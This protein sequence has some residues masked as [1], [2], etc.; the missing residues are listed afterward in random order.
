MA[1]KHHV[2]HSPGKILVAAAFFCTS[3]ILSWTNQIPVTAQMALHTR[4]SKL[5]PLGDSALKKLVYDSIFVVN[6][7]NP[8]MTE[9]QGSWITP[10]LVPRV[11]GTPAN[12]KVRKFIS[13]KMEKLGWNL[14]LDKFKSATPIGQ[15]EFVNI[16]ATKDPL[17]RNRVIVAAHY[18]SKYFPEPNNFVGAT[19]SAGP[20]AILLDLADSL[21]PLLE[22][23]KRVL[24]QAKDRG[25]EL[26]LEEQEMMDT[27]LQVVFF[28]GEEAFKEWSATDSIYGARHLASKWESTMITTQDG[29]SHNMLSNIKLFV[30][31][32]LLGAAKPQIHNLFESTGVYYDH[33]AEIERR[34]GNKL[35]LTPMRAPDN[36][37][38]EA[39]FVEEDL[40]YFV[41]GAG[42]FTNY[43]IE[44]D[45]V[46]FMQR[47]VPIVHLIPAPFPQVWHSEK[48]DGN[49]IVP[50]VL[51]DFAIIMRVFIAE[52]LQLHRGLAFIME[53]EE[54][55]KT[56]K[57]KQ[58]GN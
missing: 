33:L 37:A 2:A 41:D 6:R 43:Q 28:D 20:C 25:E 21:E 16:I 7:F 31:L 29:N 34:L 51:N 3:T 54:L 15:V 50:E 5:E 48:D 42:T 8:N 27:T 13:G 30:L 46:P 12:A 17:A 11:S 14:E 22:A 56:P 45:H 19:D 32:D 1:L 52:Y 10:L 53:H 49:A 38:D 55:E 39:Q 9:E 57:H 47:G 18:D 23:R 35:M 58:V 4:S 24:Q 26:S 40:P 44:D 36:E